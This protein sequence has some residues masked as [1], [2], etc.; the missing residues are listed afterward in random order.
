MESAVPIIHDYQDYIS[1]TETATV[2]SS[3]FE[4]ESL[5]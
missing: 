1:R 5:L 2:Q 3:T 4:F